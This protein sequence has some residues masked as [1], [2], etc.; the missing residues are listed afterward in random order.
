M[1][2][3]QILPILTAGGSM[4][5]QNLALTFLQ[6]ACTSPATISRVNEAKVGNRFAAMGGAA[7]R[8]RARGWVA[9]PTAAGARQP[10]LLGRP[11]DERRGRAAPRPRAAAAAATPAPA[12]LL[13]LIESARV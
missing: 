4:A 1:Q 13:H 3:I 5:S 6:C 8:G 12:Q 9:P 2:Y 11:G 7:V 10:E